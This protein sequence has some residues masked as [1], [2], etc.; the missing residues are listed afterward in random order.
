[1]KLSGFCPL[2]LHATLY[3]AACRLK[4][5]VTFEPAP[6]SRR[7]AAAAWAAAARAAAAALSV[8]ALSARVLSEAALSA[9]ALSEAALSA[10]AF[11]GVLTVS[12]GAG[13]TWTDVE[14][15]GTSAGAGT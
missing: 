6:Y 10:T 15:D 5:S 14:V 4:C 9:A 1:M 12:A 11:A 3:P 8:A 7:G 13:A 2:A